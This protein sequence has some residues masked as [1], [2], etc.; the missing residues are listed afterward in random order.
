MPRPQNNALPLSLPAEPDLEKLPRYGDRRQ[1]AQIHE[2]YYGRISPRTLESWPLPWR[3][4]NGRAVAETRA[5]LI[6]A[7][8][9]FDAAPTVFGGRSRRSAGTAVASRPETTT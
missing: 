1:L 4:S 5:F 8:R 6:E 7:Q 3:I 2:Q 9:R